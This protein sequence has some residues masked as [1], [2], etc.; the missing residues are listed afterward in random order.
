MP[1]IP[2]GAQIFDVVFHPTESTVYTAL[3]TG[4][5]KAF[6]YDQAT[7]KNTFSLRPLKRSCR[8]LTINDDGTRLYAAGKGK[9]IQCGIYLNLVYLSQTCS[10]ARS[11]RRPGR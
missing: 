2:V 8:A 4:H 6:A 3:L 5:V 11:T 9:A 7:H 10:P 1:D